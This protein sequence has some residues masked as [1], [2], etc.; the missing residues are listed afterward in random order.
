MLQQLHSHNICNHKVFQ[1]PEVPDASVCYTSLIRFSTMLFLLAVGNLN[2]PPRGG[3][4]WHNVHK[5][6]C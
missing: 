1:N 2:L 3:L 5:T 4:Q 6:L